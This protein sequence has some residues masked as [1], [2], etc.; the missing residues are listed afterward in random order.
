MDTK[1]SVSFNDIPRVLGE[2]YQIV[3]ELQKKNISPEPEPDRLMP[4][5]EYQDY[6]ERKT[7][8][9]P[10]RQTIYEQVFKRLIPF[11]KH[12]KFLYFKKSAIDAWLANGRRV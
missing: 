7:G 8:K 12:G 1:T 10:A 3:S 6:L 5:K 9:R 11:E 4:L 2:I